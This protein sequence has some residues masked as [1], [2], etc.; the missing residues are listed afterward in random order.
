M[1]KVMITGGAGFIGSNYVRYMLETYPDYHVTVLDKLTYAGNLANLADVEQKYPDRY[2][3]VKG[4]IADPVAVDD[5]MQGCHYVL[6]FA[7]ES[8]VD[9]S[10]E[11]PG[12]FI[13]T[14][15][16]G[17]FVLLEAARKFEVER[18]VQVSTD[19]VY[20]HI[21]EGS[22]RE[23]DALEPR[24]PYSASKAGGEHM[25]Y[26]Y[27]IT[28]GVPVM[29]T[30]GSNNY[31]PYQYPEKLIPLFITNVMDDEQV[32]VYGDGMQVRDWIFVL[33]H[34]TGIDLVLHKGEPGEYYNVGGGNERYNLE[35]TKKILE[36]TGKTD[37]LIKYVKDRPGHDRRYSLDTSKI[38]QLGWKPAYDFEEGMRLTVEWYRDN[39]AWWR[40]LKSGE[41]QDYYK[42]QYVNR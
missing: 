6:N 3:F 12:Q 25:A 2:R 26:A 9:R 28:Y 41:F 19:E 21:P 24:S 38:R 15:V 13:M 29:I 17:T 34:C 27:H 31:G 42:R 16:Y 20:G 32:P 37:S 7:A 14:D 30:R 22:S 8:H 11:Q 40:P 39:E 10:I 18:F 35:I 4:D 23:G 1:K 33:D 5:A 36:L